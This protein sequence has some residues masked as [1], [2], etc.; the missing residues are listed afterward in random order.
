MQFD[1]VKYV[2]A[3]Y[4]RAGVTVPDDLPV[5]VAT[6]TYFQQLSVIISKFNARYWTNGIILPSL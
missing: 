1:W 6:P 2:K 4:A 3:R 5:V